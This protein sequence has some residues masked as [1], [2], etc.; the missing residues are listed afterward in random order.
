MKQCSCTFQL[1]QVMLSKIM[2][3]MKQFCA[4]C[5]LP[6]HADSSWERHSFFEK[7]SPVVYTTRWFITAFTKAWYLSL[8][9]ATWVH[10]LSFLPISLRSILILSLYCPCP[11][12]LYIYRLCLACHMPCP[13]YHAN[14]VLGVVH[15]KLLIGQ[16][17][18][19][20]WHY[21]IVSYPNTP[22]TTCSVKKKPLV[23]MISLMLGFV[24]FSDPSARLVQTLFI[25]TPTVKNTRV[26][27]LILATPR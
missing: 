20:S 16:L 10:S 2:G 9:W 17:S 14:Y 11:I 1:V 26:G 15:M 6:H 13:S 22:S 24:T 8:S 18:R 21:P 27:I 7:K 19:F 3:C 4:L 25:V 23:Y 5:D 12:Y